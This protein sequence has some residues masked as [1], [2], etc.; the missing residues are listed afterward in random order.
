M[1]VVQWVRRWS[2]GNRVVQAEGQSLGGDKYLIFFSAII[3]ISV[4]LGLMDSS[5]IM[6]L[7][8]GPNSYCQQN[9]TCFDMSLLC[10]SLF[11]ERVAM[12]VKF[13][14]VLQTSPWLRPTMSN[15]CWHAFEHSLLGKA[16]LQLKETKKNKNYSDKVIDWLLLYYLLWL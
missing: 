6:I 15:M 13:K 9:L 11:H 3:F 4:L 8:N 5:D 7:C 12:T 10:L 16:R 2:S 14:Y 1:T